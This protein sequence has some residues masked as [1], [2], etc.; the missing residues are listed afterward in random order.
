MGIA[1][2]GFIMLRFDRPTEVIDCFCVLSSDESKPLVETL[3]T[4]PMRTTVHGHPPVRVTDRSPHQLIHLNNS[5]PITPRRV[6]I[7]IQEA[8]RM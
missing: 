4:N 6:D 5:K 8:V 3:V 7:I 1:L 2:Q